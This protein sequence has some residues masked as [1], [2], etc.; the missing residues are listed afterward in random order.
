[1]TSSYAA[2]ASFWVAN[3]QFEAGRKLLAGLPDAPG[4][5]G[6]S[7]AMG[8]LLQ[9]E[10]DMAGAEAALRTALQREPGSWD[11]A[12]AFFRVM[13]AQNRLGGAVLL[14][15][16]GL[17]ARGGN[18]VPH[19]LALGY[20]ALVQDQLDAASDYLGRAEEEAPD[21]T[22]VQFYLGSVHYRRGRFLEAAGAFSR[23]VK[24]EPQN[25]DARRN[26][27][28]ALGRSGR[29]AQALRLFREADPQDRDRPE[30]LNAAAFAC[31]INGLQEEGEPLIQRSF[32]VDPERSETKG[33][34]SA[35]HGRG[36]LPP[37]EPFP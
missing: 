23:V 29:V 33:L 22:E 25:V 30:L 28:L 2:V 11:A 37:P 3:G 12:E 32:A 17:A 20:I 7:L 15:R 36:R 21:Q 10:G 26:G 9:G 13:E 19:L 6:P 1:G 24:A 4:S 34:V 14:L 8:L 5:A 31:L 35:L 16:K 18:S 27:I